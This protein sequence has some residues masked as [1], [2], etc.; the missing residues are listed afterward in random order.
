M[1]IKL[2]HNALSSLF[3]VLSEARTRKFCLVLKGE[4]YTSVGNEILGKA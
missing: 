3:K 2:H 1:Q 4:S